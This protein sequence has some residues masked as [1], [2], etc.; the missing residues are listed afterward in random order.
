MERQAQHQQQNYP[1]PYQT[2]IEIPGLFNGGV[3]P[4]SEQTAMEDA[5]I[6]DFIK[7]LGGKM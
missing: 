6:Y 2:G 4:I 5:T 3:N 7:S 1:L